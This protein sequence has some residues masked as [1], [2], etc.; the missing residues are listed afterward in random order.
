MS[1]SNA[2][3]VLASHQEKWHGFDVYYTE[4]RIGRCLSYSCRVRHEGAHAFDVVGSVD[5]EDLASRQPGM[6]QR[7]QEVALARAR[8]IIDL[9]SFQ[10]GQ[11]IERS[12]AAP[13]TSDNPKTSDEQLRRRLMKVF[14]AVWQSLP[15]SYNT[16]Q[17]RVDIV[18]LCLELDISQNQY[19]AA[20]EYLLGKGWLQRS[21]ARRDDYSHVYIT[22]EGIDEHES[23]RQSASTPEARIFINYREE[24]TLGD[25]ETLGFRLKMHFGEEAVFVA[26]ERI[27]LGAQSEQRI[28]RALSWCSA[29]LVLIGPK[30]LT[31]GDE[32]GRRRLDDPQDLLRREIERALARGILIIPVL[33][34]GAQ[35][36]RKKDLPDSL[37]ELRNRQGRRI[38]EGRWER[39]TEELI[40]GIEQALGLVAHLFDRIVRDDQGTAIY[41][42]NDGQLHVIRPGDHKTARFVSSS[43]GEMPVSTEQLEL[44]PV[45]YPMESVLACELLY[46]DPGPHIYALINGRTYYVGENDLNYWA[47]NDPRE[48]RHVSQQE[49]ESYPVGRKP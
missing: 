33:V 39:D 12:P 6:L 11:S 3:S 38:H 20:M 4:D 7:I 47:R 9:Q 42:D 18:G 26:R 32:E 5:V 13:R 10:W 31:P 1:G 43:K 49:F 48:W 8:A 35:M 30:W 36:P 29:M 27:E 2:E 15:R 28:E 16:G 24:D 40:K 34:R 17:A 14:Y 22:V 41:V 19:F 21:V 37:K 46:V 23:F 45:G 25:L 44:Y